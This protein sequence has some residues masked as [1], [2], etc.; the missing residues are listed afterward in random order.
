MIYEDDLMRCARCNNA[1]FVKTEFYTLSDKPLKELKETLYMV[2]YSC[3]TCDEIKYI[4][5]ATLI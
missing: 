4:K 2:Q 3:S 5:Q 1:T